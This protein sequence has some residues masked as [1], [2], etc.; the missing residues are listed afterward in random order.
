MVKGDFTI[1]FEQEKEII[2]PGGKSYFIPGNISVKR[3][4]KL[5]KSGE[6]FQKSPTDEVVLDCFIREIYDVFLI[7][8]KELKFEEF[9][10]EM[11]IKS[12]G[13]IYNFIVNGVDPV[14][15]ANVIRENLEKVEE[16]EK[17]IVDGGS[18]QS[19]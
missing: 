5:L 7:K 17:K 6:E 18:G 2:M 11:T 12:L 16:K 3:M 8:N 4:M 9:S 13:A 1:F 14:Q 15:T 10:D 19:A